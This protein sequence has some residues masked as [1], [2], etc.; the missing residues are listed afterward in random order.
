[1]ARVNHVAKARKA[2][3]PCSKCS[4]PINPGDPYLWWEFR[5]G[6]RHVR[7]TNCPPRASELTQSAFLAMIY[8]AQDFQ[9]SITDHEQIQDLVDMVSEARDQAQESL[10]NMPE[11]LREGDTGTL[12]QERVEAC[13]Q[14]ISELGD[15]TDNDEVDWHDELSAIEYPGS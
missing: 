7:C 6:G 10:D 5:H 14:W 11:G 1:M 13:E 12:L 2:Q 9:A 8:D 4:I 15:L 3:G